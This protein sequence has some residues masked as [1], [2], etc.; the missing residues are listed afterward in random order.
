MNYLELR[1]LEIMIREWLL[2]KNPHERKI[3]FSSTEGARK[4]DIELHEDSFATTIVDFLP[5]L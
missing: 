2:T 1:N 3:R 5:P 4:S